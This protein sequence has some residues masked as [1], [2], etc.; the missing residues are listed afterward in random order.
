MVPSPAACWPAVSRTQAASEVSAREQG[1]MG[2]VQR[3]PRE[4]MGDHGVH[5]LCP[6]RHFVPGPLSNSQPS[7]CLSTEDREAPPQ[8]DST[9]GL[10]STWGRTFPLDSSPGFSMENRSPN[11]ALPTLSLSFDCQGSAFPKRPDGLEGHAVLAGAKTV[12]SSP[13]TPHP[14]DWAVRAI[15][16][17][18]SSMAPEIPLGTFK[19]QAHKQKHTV[20]HEQ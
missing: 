6:G 16:L 12:T 14:Q 8:T 2:D 1:W 4:T 20:D 7:G 17:D 3:G 15:V 13:P 9:L 5:H 11:S 18:I 10:R 19:K